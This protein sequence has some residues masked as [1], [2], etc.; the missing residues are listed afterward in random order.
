[1]L[2]SRR[3]DLAQGRQY[4]LIFRPVGG[5]FRADH[6]AERGDVH[7]DVVELSGRGV[8]T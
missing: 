5:L 3:Q 7:G 8:S 6:V 4:P 1:V 2:A